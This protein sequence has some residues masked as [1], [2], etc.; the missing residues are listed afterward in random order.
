MKLPNAVATVAVV[1]CAILLLWL[2]RSRQELALTRAQAAA[3]KA[4]KNDLSQRISD[5]EAKAVDPAIL[6][7]LEADQ[8][9]AIKLRGEVAKLRSAVSAAE[10]RAAASQ[11][12]ATQAKSSELELEPISTNRFSRVHERKLNASVA[13]GHGLV[14]GGWPVA[15][16]KQAFALA[17]PIIREDSPGQVQVQTKWP[18]PFAEYPFYK[19]DGIP[20]GGFFTDS[21]VV[22]LIPIQKEYNRTKSQMVEIK[23]ISLKPKLMYAQGSI[24]P[25]QISSEPG[26]AIPY[27]IGFPVPTVMQP[28]EVPMSM[29]RPWGPTSAG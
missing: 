20:T 16:G 17:I 8:R 27:K 2:V 21:S 3:L 24:N 6:K 26:Q 13:P 25:R 28:P 22:D 23:N 19:Y 29:G 1:A 15:P 7:R 9:E 12:A 5:L 4:T 10:T 11:N 14:F 18:W